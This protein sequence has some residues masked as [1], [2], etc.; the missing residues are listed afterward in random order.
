MSVYTILQSINHGCISIHDGTCIVGKCYITLTYIYRIFE[1]QTDSG[2]ISVFLVSLCQKVPTG[3][4]DYEA[5][6]GELIGC[7]GKFFTIGMKNS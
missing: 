5:G 6:G 2:C 3:H 7:L 1:H 4:L